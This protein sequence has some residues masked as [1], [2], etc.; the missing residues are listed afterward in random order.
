VGAIAF[1]AAKVGRGAAST[2]DLVVTVVVA[3]QV[4][5]QLQGATGTANWT[6]WTF[7][8][9]R[10]WLWLLDYAVRARTAVADG[11][12]PLLPAPLA[13][14]SGVR[15]EGVSF[16]YPGTEVDV[17][18]GVD[19]DIPAGTTVAVVGDN[20]AGK[21]TLV[22]L[23]CR[24]YEPT[25][26]RITVDGVDLKAV[27]IEGWRASTGAV[28]QDH[29]RLELPALEAVTVGDLSQLGSV[30]AADAAM[31]RA[32]SADVLGALPEG[33]ATQLGARWPEGVDLSGGQW[34]KLALGRGLMREEAILF[35]F[36]EPTAALD[37]ET[38]HRL[39]AEYAALSKRGQAERGTVTV[40]VS[41][42]FSTVRMADL[43]VVVADGRIAEAG[44]HEELVRLGGTYA[45]LYELQARAYR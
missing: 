42:R 9:V 29:A 45:E 20:G 6:A 12:Q 40:L 14:R 19:L 13:L 35:V 28:F 8:A 23:L 22:K 39:F 10:R 33:W 30:A 15:F 44:S 2:G 43:I 1:V 5:Q 34:Q 18:S 27:D 38:E 26:G 21:S 16:R 4:M 3:G 25:S 31:E 41:H 37:A 7:T 17:L 36:D 32:G 11:S 24:F